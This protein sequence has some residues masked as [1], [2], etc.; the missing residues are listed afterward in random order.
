[1]TTTLWRDAGN[2]AGQHAGTVCRLLQV[3][4]PGEDGHAPG[5]LDIGLSRGRPPPAVTVS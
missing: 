4:R 2:T 1:M 5:S 3:V